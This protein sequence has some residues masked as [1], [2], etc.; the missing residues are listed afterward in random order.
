MT[1]DSGGAL[2]YEVHARVLTNGGTV[3]GEGDALR[4]EGADEVTILLACATSFIL[5]YDKDY[6]AAI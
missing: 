1:G 5:D 4:V 2:S 3:S 6:G